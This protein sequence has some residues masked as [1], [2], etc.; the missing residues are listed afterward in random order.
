MSRYR[1]K[2]GRGRDRVCKCRVKG[3]IGR[4]KRRKNDSK[5]DR[6]T[7]HI[8]AGERHGEISPIVSGVNLHARAEAEASKNKKRP[9]N[10]WVALQNS[11]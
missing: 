4:S 5:G 11:L 6:K 7:P 1:K 8:A 9:Y 10:R 2:N 3:G